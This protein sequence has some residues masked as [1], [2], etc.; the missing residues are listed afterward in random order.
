MDASICCRYLLFRCI[1]CR[2]I[3][4]VVVFGCRCIILCYEKASSWHG[5]RLWCFR[6]CGF[7]LFLVV[8]YFWLSLLLV[9][10][11]SVKKTSDFRCPFDGVKICKWMPSKLESWHWI[12]VVIFRSFWGAVSVPKNGLKWT[13]KPRVDFAFARHSFTYF[14]GKFCLSKITH[15]APPT[16][17]TFVQNTFPFI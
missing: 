15:I 5:F 8:V 11:S 3:M 9:V 10:V 13:L 4:V 6:L 1:W 2:C 12:L 7:R 14:V 16:F 17:P